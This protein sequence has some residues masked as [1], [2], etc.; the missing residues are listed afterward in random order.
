MC[1]RNK[2]VLLL[3]AGENFPFLSWVVLMN[4]PV[5]F[6]Q[7]D[8]VSDDGLVMVS[9]EWLGEGLSGDFTPGDGGHDA[10]GQCG[11]DDSDDLPLL[12][13]SLYRKYSHALDPDDVE[14]ICEWD[15]YEEGDWMAV[16]D[17]S[18]CTMLSAWE[19]PSVIRNAAE[20]I[21]D[22]VHDGLKCFKHQKRKYESL[23]HIDAS[24]CQE[25]L[26]G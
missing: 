12:R 10:D 1:S 18:Y 11:S 17:G 6:E 16:R 13:F 14:K 5:E 7:I 21:M 20:L 2:R 8:L 22:H 24:D 4:N 15:A 23:S 9:I 26:P 25:V 19:P 3:F